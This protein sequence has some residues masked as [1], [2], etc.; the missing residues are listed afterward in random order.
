MSRPR[1][2]SSM[3]D[4][5]PV[6]LLVKSYWYNIDKIRK[7][8]LVAPEVYANTTAICIM[9]ESTPELAVK[10]QLT[11]NAIAKCQ[12]LIKVLYSEP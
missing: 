9:S 7:M 6:N 12:L 10:I 2:Q 3:S 8:E 11:E 4:L 1:D 5:L